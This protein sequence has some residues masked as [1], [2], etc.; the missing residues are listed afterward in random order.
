[1]NKL[2]KEQI[3]KIKPLIKEAP[4][5]QKVKFL[6]LMKVALKESIKETEVDEAKILSP[7]YINLYLQ[8]KKH[9]TEPILVNP[10]NPI[11]YKAMD[12][13]IDKISTLPNKIITL[14]GIFNF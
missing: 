3:A 4:I 13:L 5:E 6:K 9:G 7:H 14:I 10:N 1:M 2:I 12:A 8:L 11:P